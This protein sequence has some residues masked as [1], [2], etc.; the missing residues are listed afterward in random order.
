MKLLLLLTAILLA[1]LGVA[2]AK[3]HAVRARFH[4]SSEAPAA[5]RMTLN[6][7]CAVCNINTTGSSD[8]GSLDKLQIKCLKYFITRPST[9]NPSKD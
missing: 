7:I 3:P 1:L 4:P 9:W 2:D 5:S 6:D 8:L